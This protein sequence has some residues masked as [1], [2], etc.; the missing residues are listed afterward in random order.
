[1]G[2]KPTLGA[3][4]VAPSDFAA[5][6][7]YWYYGGAVAAQVG[8]ADWAKSFKP[9]SVVYFY[10][11]V[12]AGTAQAAQFSAVFKGT[13]VKVTTEAIPATSADVLP[14]V[15]QSGAA[16][17]SVV[18]VSVA[19]CLSIAQALQTVGFKGVKGSPDS[20]TSP[21]EIATNASVFNNWY[22][23]SIADSLDL[24]KNSP[25]AKLFLAQYAKDQGSSTPGNF[26]EEGWGLVLSMRAAL[27]HSSWAKVDSSAGAAAA[28][29]GF[30][31]PVTLGDAK[32]KCPGAAPY[33]N[34]CAQA[35]IVYKYVNGIAKAG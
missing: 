30:K 19:D 10:T 14:Q 24:T 9:K 26:A 22:T 28:F 3:I 35:G 32:I 18:Y 1:M 6:H 11:D 33:P 34:V 2:S 17:A 25:A 31:G 16:T 13:K 12:A 15:I 21:S 7:A 4:P 29:K 27:S 23:I 20:C 5:T 8:G